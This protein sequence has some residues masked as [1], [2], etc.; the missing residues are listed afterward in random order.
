MPMIAM[1]G[2]ICP[3]NSS[4]T[5]RR[6]D[7]NWDPQNS[8]ANGIDQYPGYGVIIAA[9]VPLCWGFSKS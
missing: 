1:M 3:Q 2:T 8:R 7:A 9:S 6:T 5:S 4:H